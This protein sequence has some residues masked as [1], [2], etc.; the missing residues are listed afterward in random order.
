MAFF[1]NG[2][3]TIPVVCYVLSSDKRKSL[4]SKLFDEFYMLVTTRPNY[5]ARGFI[6]IDCPACG[7]RRKRGGFAPT[8]TGGFR[9]T[10]FNGGC[11]FSDQPTGWEEGNGLSGRVKQ[12]F[13][14]LGGDVQHIPLGDRMRHRSG[15]EQKGERVE[16]ATKFPEISMPEG[17]EFLE[18][19]ATH[20]TRASGVLDYLNDRS[21]L[22]MSMSHSAY[23]M[24][25]PIHPNHLILPYIHTGDRIVGY[26][27]RNT[28][29]DDVDKR[30]IQRSPPDFM[31]NQ[32]LLSSSDKKYVF[33]L[34]SPMDAILLKG[35]ATRSNRIS[36]KQE[37]LIKVSG[38]IP[39]LIPDQRGD[40]STPFFEVA[41]K[42]NWSISVPDWG[43]KDAGESITK[44]G[45]LSTIEF[46]TSSM[47]TNYVKIRHKL[48]IRN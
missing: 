41:K 44:H 39:V 12:L 7:D 10:C 48:G 5:S 23:F 6:N 28:A 30:F 11:I 27:G 34:E 8:Q 25:S 18:D 42:N 37:N 33:V 32:Y 17:T 26:M 3:E 13:E 1:D 4:M 2:V 20:D 46:I 38:K 22:Y 47:S 24:W 15:G 35:V 43:C 45:L 9:Y 16:L 31:F 40:E 21:P 36:K 14:L 19:A 29:S